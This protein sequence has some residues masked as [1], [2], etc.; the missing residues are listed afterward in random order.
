M[1]YEIATYKGFPYDSRETP[2]RVVGPFLVTETSYPVRLLLTDRVGNLVGELIN[3][4]ETL[5]KT[6]KGSLTVWA[7]KA[8]AKRVA[9]FERQ[10]ERAAE[11]VREAEENLALLE[12]DIPEEV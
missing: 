8:Q 6:Y 7:R 3:G 9:T 10:L 11:M 4:Y 2:V 1:G 5:E 12:G